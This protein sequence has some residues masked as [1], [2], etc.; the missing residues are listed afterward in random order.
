MARLFFFFLV[1]NL[2]IL[3]WFSSLEKIADSEDSSHI[4]FANLPPC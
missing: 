4:C 2:L 1:Q 3:E